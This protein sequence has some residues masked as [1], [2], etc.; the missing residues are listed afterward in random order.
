[1]G[2]II[3]ICSSLCLGYGLGIITQKKKHNSYMN[4][5]KKIN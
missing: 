5:Y 1:M 2:E 4:E 3:I